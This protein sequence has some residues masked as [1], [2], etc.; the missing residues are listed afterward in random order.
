MA[1]DER[2]RSGLYTRLVDALGAEN[3]DT[4]FELLPADR[5]ALATRAEIDARFSQVD[6]RFAQVDTR[7]AQV[8][9]RFD[10]ID[11]RF[12]AVDARFDHLEQRLDDRLDGLRHELLAAFR[13]ELVAAV[14]GQTRAVIVATA[15]ATFGIG[16]LAV[17][18][19][20]LL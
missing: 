13:G 9:A 6:A 16:G 1:V 8:D 18:L 20:Q 15:T 17:T 7:F 11:E 19:A 4:M 3:A 12:D 14:S 2:R 10:A 5:D